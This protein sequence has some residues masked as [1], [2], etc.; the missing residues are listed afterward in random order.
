[1]SELTRTALGFSSLAAIGYL[2]AF[3][4]PDET[5]GDVAGALGMLIA[6]CGFAML[7]CSLLEPEGASQ[8]KRASPRRRGTFS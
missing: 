4:N 5:L 8:T 1:M 7:V 3:A 2:I 6:V